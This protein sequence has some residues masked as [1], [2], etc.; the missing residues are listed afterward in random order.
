MTEIFRP[1]VVER[2]AGGR[3]DIGQC[4]SVKVTCVS[5]VGWWDDQK[6]KAPMMALG[7]PQ[8]ADQWQAAWDSGN[9]A[10]ACTLVEVEGLDGSLRRLLLDAGWNPAYMAW[11]FQATGLDRR[12]AQGE[13]DLL[14]FSHEHMDHFWGLEAVLALNP[15][16]PMM[17]PSTFGLNALKLIFGGVFPACGAANRHPHQ[18]GLVKAEPGR[19]YKL[20]DGCAAVTF[21][22]PIMLGVR[23]E[24]SLFFNVADK[25]LVCLAGCSHQGPLNLCDF[26]R[27]NIEGGQRLYGLYGGLHLAPLQV[28][29]PAAEEV[30]Q[31]LGGYGLEVMAVNHCT[32]RPAVEMMRDLGYPVTRGSASQG[33]RTD[34]YVGNGDGV[35]F[36]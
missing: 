11:R 12:L 28:L 6:V 22:L 20:W 23:G 17:I 9:A 7:G 25:G 19:I 35:V 36:G 16:L 3:A 18:G 24:Q 1:E 29:E 26:G 5:E 27:D 13:V 10:G 32:G 31:R 33:S 4:K 2:R 30:I 14:M 34:L 8:Q 21:D 15:A